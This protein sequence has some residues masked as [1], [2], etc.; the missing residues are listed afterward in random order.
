MVRL[1]ENVIEKEWRE[2]ERRIKKSLRK[3]EEE[4]SR[5]REK[6]GG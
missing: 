6:R 1:G 2:M 5:K 4:L 3:T